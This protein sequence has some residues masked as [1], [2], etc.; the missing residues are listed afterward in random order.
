MKRA[1]KILL[2]SSLTLLAVFIALLCSY[3]IITADARLDVSKLI[4]YGQSIEILDADGNKIESTSLSGKRKSVL[5]KDLGQNTINAFI[6]SEDRNFYKH[7]GLNYKRMLKALY[8]NITT[9]SFKEGA[10]TISQ[11]LIKNTHLSNDKTITRKLKEIRLTKQLERKYSKNE[12]LEMYLNTIY[13]GHNCYGLQSAANFY[14]SKNAEELNLAESATL[15]GLLTS[16]NNFSPF[17]NCEKSISRR[18]TVLKNMYSCGFINKT[19]LNSA[20][21]QPLNANKTHDG[22]RFGDY[23]SAVLDELE[24][25]DFDFYGNAAQCKIYT[26][27]NREIQSF[28]E[29]IP[30]KCDNSVI[31]TNNNHGVEAYKTT[32]NGAKRQP[33]STIKPLLVYA[34]AIENKIIHTF[35]KISDEKVDYNGYSPENYDKKYH[36]QVTVAQ[37]VANSYN[38]PAVKTLNSLS[39]KQ[40]ENYASL[41]DINLDDEEKN[42]ALALGGMK[43][44]LSL[45]EICDAYDTFRNGGSHCK[46]GFI[47]QICNAN[48]K[49]IYSNTNEEKRV[50]SEGTAS[51]INEML[52]ETGKSGT[53]KKLKHFKFDIA[54]K[55]GTCGN[56]HGNTDAY[57]ISYT[58]DATFGIWLGDRNCERLNVTGGRD[59]CNIM[60]DLLSLYYS[61]YEPQ[62]LEVNA[63]TATIEI[64]RQEYDKHGKIMLADKIAPTA[65]KLKVKCHCKNIPTD[66]SLRF[67]EPTISKPK[68]L[69][70]NN[71]TIIELCQAEYYSYVIKRDNIIV[72]DGKWLDKF[73]DKPTAGTYEY[74][75]TPYYS[76]G[77]E[78]HFGKTIKLDKI[79][80]GNELKD[81]RPPGIVYKDWYNQ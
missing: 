53:A 70:D 78:R 69:V 2:L 40:A 56:T 14:F 77:K 1:I 30:Y 6:A 27:L 80:I 54:S 21:A 46:S 38:I 33:G 8:T 10:S 62:K 71:N 67:T 81:N 37:S 9:R 3:Y 20:A 29:N 74:S 73:T 11:Q 59:C 55:T 31:I 58:A 61:K 48:G 43:H 72:Y 13:F 47:K 45:K 23:V 42:L 64:D 22:E 49:T 68:I 17:K 32:I 44:G 50:F 5:L 35:T 16:P 51:L 28:I 15:A 79:I 65:C 63:G 36:G 39:I 12:I 66:R 41:L 57:A 26:Y 4:N 18:N 7:N 24:D 34:P 75:V 19:D 25:I 76:D 60:K 52:I